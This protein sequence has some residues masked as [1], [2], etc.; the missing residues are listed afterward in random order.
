MV[1]QGCTAGT[2]VAEAGDQATI[3]KK[4]G[5]KRE[6]QNPNVSDDNNF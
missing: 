3:K 6:K 4:E 1:A 2:Q 5:K